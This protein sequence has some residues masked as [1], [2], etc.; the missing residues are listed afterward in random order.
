MRVVWQLSGENSKGQTGVK[1][2]RQRV[3]KRLVAEAAPVG[4]RLEEV[5]KSGRAGG[6]EELAP[7]VGDPGEGRETREPRRT[8]EGK[9]NGKASASHRRSGGGEKQG[10]QRQ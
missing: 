8:G 1:E 5:R 10:S 3:A 9:R 4:K 6:T 7:A 2:S